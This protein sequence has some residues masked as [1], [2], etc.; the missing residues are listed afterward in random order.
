MAISTYQVTLKYKTS[1][2]GNYTKLV[3][4]KD[5]P[6]LIP[7]PNQLETTTLSDD[8]QT[9]IAGI[10]QGAG[11][12]TFTIN[13]DKTDCTTIQGLEGDPLWF[14]LDFSDGTKFTWEGTLTLGVPSKG[15]D[16]VIEGTVNIVPTS[17][18]TLA[19]A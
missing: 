10:K 13:W 19:F 3:D 4:I 6:E 17:T 18:V 5:F 2:S 11:L 7:N 14:E 1:S 16:E 9:F 8:M 12:M 15:V